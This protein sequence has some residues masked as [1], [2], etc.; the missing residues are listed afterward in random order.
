MGNKK[1]TVLTCVCIGLAAALMISSSGFIVGMTRLKD[2]LESEN[3]ELSTKNLTLGSDIA[4]LSDKLERVELE[5]RELESALDDADAYFEQTY[6]KE[7]AEIEARSAKLKEANDALER[8]ISLAK[9]ADGV[10]MTKLYEHIDAMCERIRNGSPLVRVKL[11]E[12]ELEEQKKNSDGMSERLADHKWESADKYIRLGKEVLGEKYS[13]ALDMKTVLEPT[14]ASVPHIAVYYKDIASG[15]S[16]SYNGDDVFDSASVMKAPY[17]SAVLKACADYEAGK[18]ELDEDDELTLEQLEAMFDLEEKIK[19]EHET[20]DVAGSGVLKDAEEGSE[21]SYKELLE[22]SLKNSDNIAFSLVRKHF[23]NKWY[24][25][26]ASGCGA[27]SPLKNYMNMSVCEAGTMFEEMYF[28]MLSDTEYGEFLRDSMGNSAHT[29]LSVTALAG[30][31]AHKYGWD[32][33]AYHDAAIVLG[34]RPYIAIV[35]TDIDCGGAVA[36]KYIRSIFDDI[37]AIHELLA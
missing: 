9:N 36:D 27:V 1:E 20:M 30:K 21:Y 35:F 34:E 31:V 26:F 15:H 32:I 16:F 18:L 6:E 2:R 22:L 17:I 24:Y 5:K 37:E 8:S 4:S 19:L 23:T 25:D 28:Y 7:L 3:T 11:T 10:D 33:D 29:V 14:G 12:E 13:E